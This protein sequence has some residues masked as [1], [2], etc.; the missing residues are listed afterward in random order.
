MT[1]TVKLSE[2]LFFL[3]QMKSI[4]S[5]CYPLIRVETRHTLIQLVL[6]EGWSHCTCHVSCSG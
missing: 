6:F 5:V 2:Q 3:K 4:F 1:E